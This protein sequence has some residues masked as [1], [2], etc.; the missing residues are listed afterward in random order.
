MHYIYHRYRTHFHV[1][2]VL[3]SRF[4]LL[5]VWFIA[6]MWSIVLCPGFNHMYVGSA[7]SIITS[8]ISILCTCVELCGCAIVCNR[9]RIRVCAHNHHYFIYLFFPFHSLFLMVSQK[10]SCPQLTYLA[11]SFISYSPYGVLLLFSH[12]AIHCACHHRLTHPCP[13]LPGCC[14]IDHTTCSASSALAVPMSSPRPH[15]SSAC[16]TRSCA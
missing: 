6:S 10:C 13:L 3:N 5:H 9:I 12:R 2:L 15:H 4:I 8:V 11:T 1:S 7:L 14:A 16:C